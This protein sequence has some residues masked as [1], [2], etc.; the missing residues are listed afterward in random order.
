MAVADSLKLAKDSLLLEKGKNYRR[1]F[2]AD[3]IKIENEFANKA[4]WE[5]LK[6]IAIYPL[7]NVARTV[8]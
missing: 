2:T 3:S 6:K 8:A 4:K 1:Q 7:L 5:R